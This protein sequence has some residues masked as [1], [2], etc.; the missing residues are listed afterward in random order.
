[1][2]YQSYQWV[3]TAAGGPQNRG[4]VQDVRKV[5]YSSNTDCYRTYFRYPVEFAEHVKKTM[6]V[7]NYAGFAYADWFPIDID[8]SDIERALDT[9]RDLLSRLEINMDIDV[10]MLP[11]FFSG[12]KGFHVYIP[13]KVMRVTPS[14]NISQ[15]FKFFVKDLLEPWNIKYDTA[16]YDITR[17]FRSANTV[18][19]KTGLYKVQLDINELYSLTTDGIMELA[20]APRK[21]EIVPAEENEM[22]VAMYNRAQE[23]VNEKPKVNGTAMDGDM[24]EIPKNA[25]LCY[26]ELLKGVGEGKRD[27]SAYLLCTYFRKQGYP[28]EMTEGLMQAW[29][30]RNNPPMEVVEI[31]TKVKSAYSK[32][33]KFDH[34]CNHELLRQY[35]KPNCYLKGKQVDISSASIVKTF[36]EA[37]SAYEHYTKNLLRKMCHTGLPGIGD[38]MRG[39]SPGEVCTIVARSGV[40]KTAMLLNILM[41]VA[42]SNPVPQL[43]FSMEQPTPQIFERMAQIATARSGK[44]VE[45]IY[46]SGAEQKEIIKQETRRLFDRLLLVDKDFLTVEQMIDI[47]RMAEEHKTG[48]KI[49]LVAIDYLGRM[50]RKG[51]D[52]TAAMGEAAQAVKHMA[53][54]LDVAVIQ[55]AQVNRAGKDGTAELT[56]DMIRDSGEIEEASDFVIGMWRPDMQKNNDQPEDKLR[57]KL[58]KNRKGPNEIFH[59]FKFIK[60]LLRVDDYDKSLWMDL[61]DKEGADWTS[62]GTYV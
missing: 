22:L 52:A 32:D 34:G 61:P 47:V 21:V 39:I 17:L 13:A 36:D 49:G 46:Q 35:C 24:P 33:A 12:A 59:D 30:K 11:V 50:G 28:Q 18:N 60:R 29:N 1:M 4:V 58:L 3:E 57:V 7:K 19:S 56:M 6:S 2:E 40:G 41:R 26:Y 8:D 55:L 48:E 25:K 45:A 16:I 54:E 23:V 9:T 44:D 10:R 42:I 37:A 31:T 51:K 43:F 53:K 20:K 5:K 62:I 14:K 15:Y 38:A 27:L